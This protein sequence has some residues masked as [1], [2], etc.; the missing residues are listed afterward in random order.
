M[1][2]DSKNF[3]KCFESIE[4]GH[5]RENE[6]Y[7]STWYDAEKM[8][9]KIYPYELSANSNEGDIYVSVE[10]YIPDLIPRWC[11]NNSEHPLLNYKLF[12][13]GNLFF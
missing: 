8:D 13:N 10:T 3:L 6:G 12:K 2:L 9:D 4:I 5:Y 7:F 11:F 1:F